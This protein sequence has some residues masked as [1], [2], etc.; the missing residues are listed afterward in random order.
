MAFL[1][2]DSFFPAAAKLS[3]N[4][5]ARVFD[6]IGSFQANPASPGASLE[7]VKNA[8][9]PQVWSARITRDLRA[10]LFKDGDSWVALHADH[11]DD[12]YAWAERHQV[13]RH[14]VTGALQVVEVVESRETVA[15]P[16]ATE[17]PRV[18][19]GHSDAYLLS[20]GVPEAWLPVLREVADEDQLLDVAVKLP[21]DVAERL[22]TLSSGEL[23]TPP[24]PIPAEKPLDE[25]PEARQQF[26][27][28]EDRS[29]LRAVLDAPLERWVAFLHPSQRSLVD[30]TFNG[31]AKVTGSAGTGKTTVAMHRARR[32]AREGK[33]VLLTT[34]VK[35]LSENIL[36][37]LRL[38]CT[39]SELDRIQVSTVHARALAIV[40]SVDSRADIAGTKEVLQLLDRMR[41]QHAPTLD[42]AFVRAEWENVVQIQGI[43][44]W[45]D[46]RSAKRSGRGKP[47]SVAE[48]KTLWQVFDG[49]LDALRG[50]RHY[51]WAGICRYA[52]EL[53]TAGKVTSPYYAVLVD[54]VQDLKAPELRFL[55]A[56]CAANLGELMLVGDAGQRIYPGG[57]SLGALGIDV[58]GRSTVLR[59]NY[60]TTEQIRRAADAVLGI[61]ADDLDSGKEARNKTRSLLRGPEPELRGYDL[62]EAELEAGVARI[63]RW[64]ASGIPARAIAVFVR[65]NRRADQALDALTKAEVPAA[66]LADADDLPA[67]GVQVGTMHRAKGLEFRAVLVLDC[68]AGVVPNTA[69]L[70]AQTDPHD[71]ETAEERERRLLYVAMTRARD[72]LAISWTRQPSPFL[73]P[74]LSKPS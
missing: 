10:I 2:A 47:L 15:S 57:F 24:T 66:A 14:S 4:E 45:A 51:D 38:L 37:Q 8:R 13:G 44:T 25:V 54:E 5:K 70:D 41:L 59:L 33:E 48:R 9:S 64:I 52:E 18:F 72:Q 74:L 23:V 68:S 32:L 62:H 65:T 17:L 63:R 20:L 26:Y 1:L 61:E 67:T 28:V 7:R 42:A 16:A 60:R 39:R 71:R 21:P 31:P 73:A 12:A 27:V 11:H 36:R 43:A 35:T 49:V 6:F 29:D 19:A 22:L 55:R 58:R 46:Y 40:R 69:T 50:R 56:L 3:A 34:F 53:L 30:K